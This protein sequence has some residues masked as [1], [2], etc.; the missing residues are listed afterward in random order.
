V[1]VTDRPDTPAPA[2]LHDAFPPEEAERPADRLA[3]HPTPEPGSRPNLAEVASGALARDLP[4]R[5]GGR[6]DLERH[7]AARERRRNGAGVTAEW[8]FTTADARIELR[9]L[10][11]TIEA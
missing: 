4:E 5:V 1:P 10:H 9:K 8:R 3:I 2:G 6:P 7:V 11:P